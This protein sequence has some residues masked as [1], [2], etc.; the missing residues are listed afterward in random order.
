MYGVLEMKKDHQLKMAPKFPEFMSNKKVE[1]FTSK[2]QLQAKE[3]QI[4]LEK[5]KQT[6]E[7]NRYQLETE[8]QQLK[9]TIEKILI[10]FDKELQELEKQKLFTDN[11]I[12]Q[13]ELLIANLSLSIV[14][15][16]ELMKWECYIK[17]KTNEK[18]RQQVHFKNKQNAVCFLVC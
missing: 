4:A 16:S 18:E 9:E 3:Y 11:V 6:L 12:Y 13:E 7:T 10:L 5:Y 1:D 2:E 17:Y 8:R 14:V 15:E